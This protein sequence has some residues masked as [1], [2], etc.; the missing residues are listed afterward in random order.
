MGGGPGS[1]AGYTCNLVV[2]IDSTG[3]WFTSGFENQV[4]NDKW[5][6]I[7][8]HPGYVED[9]ADASDAVWGLAPTSACTTN[10]DNPD[11]V[12][13]N[14]YSETLTDKNSLVTAINKAVTNFK[15][16][17]SRLKRIDILTMTR[18]PDNMPCQSGQN[19][20]VVQKYVDDAVAAVVSAGPPAVVASPQFHAKD[21]SIFQDGGPHFTDAGKPVAAKIYGDYY[22]TE[23]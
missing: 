17:Y 6:I 16:K 22:S 4:P 13:F 8:H 19:G 20:A 2:G 18:S 10:S 5:Q 15:N 23:P 3:E 7:Y 11:R 14:V 9:W 21:C 12:I 1:T